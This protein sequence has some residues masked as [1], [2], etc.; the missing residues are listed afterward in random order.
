MEKLLCVENNSEYC[1]SFREDDPWHDIEMS[2]IIGVN[3]EEYLIILNRNNGYQIKNDIHYTEDVVLH[4]T[5]TWFKSEK[6]CLNAIK[7]IEEM[8][9]C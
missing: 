9:V 6:D 1:I 5:D 3:Y 4:S 8:V 7:E 2:N